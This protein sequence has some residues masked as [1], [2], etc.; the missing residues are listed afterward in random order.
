[1]SADA[2]QPTRPP[3]PPAVLTGRIVAI[4]RRLSADRA[5]AVG[6][7]LLGAGVRAFELT[8]NDPEAEALA[9]IDM[10]ATRLGE[11]LLVGA[12][13]VLSVRSAQRAVDAGARF[14]VS[15]HTDE[16]LVAWAAGRGIPALPGAM[17]P[18]EVIRAW[19]AGAAGVKL[20]P[21]SV[22]GP[23][24]IRELRG[25]LPDVP[26]I[27]TGGIS[28]E[29]AGAFVGAGA[30]AVGLGSWLIG[31]GGAAGVRARAESV[32]SAIDAAVAGS[33]R[34]T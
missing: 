21:A 22:V 15:P 1:M 13:T 32:R 29:N 3:L 24:F 18:T 4:G 26:I 7:A 16:A 11:D 25:P 10:L 27:P 6:E 20:F 5:L 17:T 12:G 19:G 8:L 14:L 2:P 33:P 23:A 28:A 31:D 34:R 9:S 30:V